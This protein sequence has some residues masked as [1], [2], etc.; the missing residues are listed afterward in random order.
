M[1]PG[2][3]MAMM[4]FKTLGYITMSQGTTYA[5]DQKMAVYMKVPPKTIFWGQ[6]WA[7]LWSC[8]VQVAVVSDFILSNDLKS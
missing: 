2:R 5:M 4:A 8:V 3:P 7:S 6:F 1:L